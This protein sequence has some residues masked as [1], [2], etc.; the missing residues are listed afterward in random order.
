MCENLVKTITTFIILRYQLDEYVPFTL[1]IGIIYTLLASVYFLQCL[2]SEFST[3]ILISY[4]IFSLN[5]NKHRTF[6][7]NSVST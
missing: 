2:N 5:S 7:K 6:K 3:D 1:Q 4:G